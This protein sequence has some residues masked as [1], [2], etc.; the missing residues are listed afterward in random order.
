MRNLN[1]RF[2]ALMNISSHYWSP[3]HANECI[4]SL[5]EQQK[6]HLIINSSLLDLPSHS[7]EQFPFA[8]NEKNK[9]LF[10][11]RWGIPCR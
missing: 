9:G 7:H 4:F 6:V 2:F 3:F 1:V 5:N 11:W 8:D 10:T